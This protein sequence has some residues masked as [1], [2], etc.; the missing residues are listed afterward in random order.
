MAAGTYMEDFNAGANSILHVLMVTLG[1]SLVLGA[2]I[3]W[4]M[5][6]R[7]NMIQGYLDY[8]FSAFLRKS[9]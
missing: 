1:F 7:K 5:T 2:V 3:V 9:R 8:F 6:G 4:L